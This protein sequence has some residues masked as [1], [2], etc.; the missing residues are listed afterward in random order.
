MCI[1]RYASVCASAIAGLSY[2]SSYVF[3]S[4]DL[5]FSL[6]LSLSLPMQV[7]VL[8]VC[9]FELYMIPLVLLL[10]LAWNYILISSGKDTRQDVVS[11]PVMY[12]Y[13]VLP[14]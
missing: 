13:A 11:V 4:I 5:Q 1:M 3:L 14:P 10:P 7:C 9:N 6:S 12:H 8:V 2:I